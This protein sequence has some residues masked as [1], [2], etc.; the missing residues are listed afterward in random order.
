[1]LAEQQ[2]GPAEGQRGLRQ[3]QP[4]DARDAAAGEPGVQAKKPRH[5][6]TKQT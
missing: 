4:A 5:I 2:R 3:L 1:M 6:A